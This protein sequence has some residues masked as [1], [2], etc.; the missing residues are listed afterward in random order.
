M[1]ID[2]DFIENIITNKSRR[3][4]TLP[5]HFV[6]M[7][8]G[9]DETV[10]RKWCYKNIENRFYIGKAPFLINKVFVTKT[11]VAFE[12]PADA[13]FFGLIKDSL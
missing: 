13:T 11:I 5:P 6:K 12:N 8:I 10:V 4:W 1:A 3:V 7:Q 2:E 9:S